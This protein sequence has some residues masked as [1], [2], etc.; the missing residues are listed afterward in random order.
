MGKL[1]CPCAGGSER[2]R[3]AIAFPYH[4]A[5]EVRQSTGYVLT[6][7]AT[8]RRARVA[9]QERLTARADRSNPDVRETRWRWLGSSGNLPN[10]SNARRVCTR[11]RDRFTLVRNDED[12]LTLLAAPFRTAQAFGKE[13][14]RLALRADDSDAIGG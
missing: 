5:L 7:V 12:R 3:Q 13:L 4:P 6:I 10:Q 2:H 8:M 11:G 1:V 14:E 9:G